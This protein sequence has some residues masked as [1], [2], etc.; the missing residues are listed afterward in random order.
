MVAGSTTSA[1]ARGLG[2]ELLVHADEQ[3]LARKA[4]LDPLLLGRD[5]D[6]VGV[7]DEQ[8]RD[9]RPARERIALAAQDRRRCATGRAC[10]ST[11]R[12]RP[13]PSIIVLF[14]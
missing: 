6:R 14:Q 3:I 5:R 2:H 10:G 12:A 13:S 9:R 4:A 7:L 11:D 8:R 1:I